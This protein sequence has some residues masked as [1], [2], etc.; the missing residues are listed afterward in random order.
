MQIRKIVFSKKQII[1][2]ILSVSAI[3][4]TGC[5]GDDGPMGPAGPRG[6]QGI[7]GEKGTQGE[8]GAQ[9]AQGIP[10]GSGTTNVHSVQYVVAPADWTGDKNGYWATLIVKEI[11]S[12]IYDSGA[13][14][15]YQ[16]NEDDPENK[17]FNMLP[18]TWVND[19]SVEYMDFNVYVGKIEISIKWVDGGKNSSEAPAGDYI[20]K[21]V[22]I[23]GTQ[24]SVLKNEVN[25][26]NYK[27]VVKYF[28]LK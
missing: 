11:T 13:V 19:S 9:G 17:Y 21:I 28:G 26:S 10:G 12:G 14:L 25:V 20:F 15:V 23:E 27:A 22:I 24:L 18:Y 16:L 1:I 5:K 6:E 2:T 4:L 7:Q 3:L 8:K